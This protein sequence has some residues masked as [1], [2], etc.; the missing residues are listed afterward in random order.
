VKAKQKNYVQLAVLAIG[1]SCVA[2]ANT[3]TFNADGSTTV[4]G[5][6][7]STADTVFGIT[8]F[9][10]TGFTEVAAGMQVDVFFS[11]GSHQLVDWTSNS[12]C[13]A[14]TAA[15]ST[16]TGCGLAT[17]T[18]TGG[19]WTLT[20]TGDPGLIAGAT[21]SNPQTNALDPWTLT[22]TSTSVAITEVELIGG[23]F[24]VFDRDRATANGTDS[25][26]GS[27]GT[28]NS[29]AGI[30]WEAPSGSFTIN[31]TYDNEVGL[32]TPQ[33]CQNFSPDTTFSGNTPCGDEWNNLTFSFTGTTL[34]EDSS[35]VFYQD[36]DEVGLPEP[37]T[38][39]LV[40][41]GVLA[42]VGGRKRLLRRAK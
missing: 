23:P 14:T 6:S 30:T 5:N 31:V 19:T 2:Q 18:I 17:G 29:G 22:N 10:T 40:G 21:T 13:D 33:A 11:D 7:G 4:N 9:T 16:S 41:I 1:L 3:I 8:T 42:L 15:P 20:E 36:T 32:V 38:I 27:V 37:T 34:F 28:P 35:L 39:A 26:V 25:T 24:I 12:V